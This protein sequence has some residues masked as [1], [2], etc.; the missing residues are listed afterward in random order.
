M[1]VVLQYV[2][3]AYMDS[4]LPFGAVVATKDQLRVQLTLVFLQAH[5]TRT[6]GSYKA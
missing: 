1:I 2:I 3:L 4:M 5:S 6:K